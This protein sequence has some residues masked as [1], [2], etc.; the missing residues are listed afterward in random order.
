MKL[1]GIQYKPSI[2]TILYLLLTLVYF[3]PVFT[4]LNINIHLHLKNI[5]IDS[6]EYINET[7]R[8]ICHLYIYTISIAYLSIL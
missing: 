2:Y 3:G 4:S 8:G 1:E 5:Y 6:R 7:G